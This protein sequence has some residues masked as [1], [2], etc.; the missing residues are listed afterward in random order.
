MAKGKKTGGRDFKKGESGNPNGRPHEKPEVRALK[1]LTKSRFEDVA[2]RYI[3]ST[4]DELQDKFRDP[5]TPALDLILIKVLIDAANKGDIGKLNF[6]LERLIGKITERVDI[7]TK[8]D[9]FNN[10]ENLSIADL[11]KL[12]GLAK[13][14]QE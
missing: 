6:F 13:K 12:R 11:E 1:R 14:C 3:N 8:G 2:H 5:S 7:T 4:V 9:S 10:L